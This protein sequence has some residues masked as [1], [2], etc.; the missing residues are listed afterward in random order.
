[1]NKDSSKAPAP[2]PTAQQTEGPWRNYPYRPSDGRNFQPLFYNMFLGILKRSW[3]LSCSS[4]LRTSHDCPHGDQR[5]EF[6]A[7]PP[8]PWTLRIP[9]FLLR[10]E[11]GEF[12]WSHGA[13]EA[14]IIWQLKHAGRS[15]TSIGKRQ[16][17][18]KSPGTMH[19]SLRKDLGALV[20]LVQ[21]RTGYSTPYSML[22]PRILP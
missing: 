2:L 8:R 17:A 16:P 6:W 4:L 13:L 11:A 10:G 7:C 21:P 1:M 5:P 20:T 19:A 9:C 3:E 12:C 15:E 14:T 18:G 22:V